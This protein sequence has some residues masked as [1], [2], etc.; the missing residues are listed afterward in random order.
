MD[1]EFNGRIAFVEDYDMHMAHYLAHG[2]DV[3]LN[4]PRRLLEACGTSGMKASL[5]GV[6]HLSVR[7]GWWHE[8]YNG[9]NG[10]AIGNDLESTSTDEQDKADAEALYRL[11]EEDIVPL[12][13]DRDRKGVPHSWISVIKEAIRSVAPLFCARRMMKEYIERMYVPATQLLKDKEPG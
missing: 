12:Y 2:V 9:A 3:W 11:L 4:T 7:D 6:I 10:W 13:Y 5:N 1:R 8:G